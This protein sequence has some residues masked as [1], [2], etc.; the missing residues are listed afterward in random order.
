MN[1]HTEHMIS[2]LP[3]VI[4][5]WTL[6]FLAVSNAHAYSDTEI[7]QAIYQAEGGSLTK[8]PFGIRSVKC[9][10]YY[11]CERIC[12]NTIHNNRI[13]FAKQNKYTDFIEF[14]G[15]DTV[16]LMHTN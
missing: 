11:D 5:L 16:R 10:G 2:L 12:L 13:R 3:A 14:L 1:R 4:L 7:S 9:D 15:S 6:L 8:Y